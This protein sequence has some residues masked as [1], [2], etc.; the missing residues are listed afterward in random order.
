MKSRPRSSD[1][2]AH[3]VETYCL[4]LKTNSL[5]TSLLN[6]QSHSPLTIIQ[7]SSVSFQGRSPPGDREIDQEGKVALTARLETIE[8]VRASDDAVFV[9]PP[10]ATPME[11]KRVRQKSVSQDGKM[12]IS[13]GV[14]QG[15]VRTKV[16]VNYPPIAKAARV[17]GAVVLQAVIGKDGHVSELHVISGPPMLQQ[18]ALDSVK[19]WTYEPFLLNGEV[20]EGLT[21]VNVEFQIPM[22]SLQTLR[23]A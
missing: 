9:P 18:A 5:R 2:L 23:C 20:M 12:A 10:D 17:H 13:S 19:Q 14:S 21:T 1:R 8:P 16:A 7:N 22:R 4:D 3:L 11:I 15:M 6:F